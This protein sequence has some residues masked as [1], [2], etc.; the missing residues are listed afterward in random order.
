LYF[1]LLLNQ[2]INILMK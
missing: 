1:G 2:C